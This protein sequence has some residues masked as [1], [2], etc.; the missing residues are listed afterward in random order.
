MRLQKDLSP[1]PLIPY[2]KTVKKELLNLIR[3]ILAYKDINIIID[4][5]IKFSSVEW[6]IARINGVKGP[7]IQSKIDSNIFFYR[8]SFNEST[9]K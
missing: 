6:L 5:S 1:D 8:G 9:F 2:K 4:K 7:G 3:K